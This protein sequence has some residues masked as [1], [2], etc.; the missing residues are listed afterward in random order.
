MHYRATA[1]CVCTGSGYRTLSTSQATLCLPRQQAEKKKPWHVVSRLGMRPH[2]CHYR[3]VSLLAGDLPWR[4][5]GVYI[6]STDMRKNASIGF[7]KGEYGGRQWLIKPWFIL[8]HSELEGSVKT[9]IYPNTN[10]WDTL[11]EHLACDWGKWGVGEFC[12]ASGWHDGV[13]HVFFPLK[14]TPPLY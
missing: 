7:R 13:L 2:L 5:D 1:S 10:R 8:N 9:H 11:T 6:L 4:K 14:M 12:R 3:R